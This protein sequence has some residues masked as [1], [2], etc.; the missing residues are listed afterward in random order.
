MDD[1]ELDKEDKESK[2]DKSDVVARAKSRLTRMVRELSKTHEIGRECME[3]V[4]GDQWEPDEIKSRTSTGRQMITI[5]RLSPFVNQVV[6]KNAME[7]ARIRAVPFEDAD[8]DKGK[9]VNGL[10][11]HIQSSDKSN[12]GEAFSNTFFHLGSAGFGYF[13]ID[14]EYCNEKSMDQEVLIKKIDDP[15]SVYLDPDGDFCIIVDFMDKDT[16]KEEYKDVDGGDWDVSAEIDKPDVDDVMRVE[17]FERTWKKTKLY[18]IQRYPVDVVEQPDVE[19]DLDAAIENSATP[20]TGNETNIVTVTQEELDKLPEGTFEILKERETKIPTVKR[21]VF[22]GDEQL[23]VDDWP[24]R[25]IPIIGCFARQHTLK[26][27]DKFYKAIVKD[28]ID[29]Q[30]MYN[31]YKSQDA[32]LM[33]QAPKSTWMGAQGSFKGFERDYD[34][35]NQVATARLEYNPVVSNGVMAPPPQRVAP[36]M[37]SQGFYTN[38]TMA[39]DEIKACIGI[40]DPSLGE[41]GNEVAARAILARQKQGDISTFHYTM[42]FNTAMYQAGV[43]IVDLIPHIYDGPRV[44]RI[45][46]DDM[47]D[48]VIRINQNYVDPKDGK[49]KLYDLTVGEYD[50]KVDIGASSTT[51]RMDAAENLLEFSRVVPKAGEIGADMI[52]SNLDFENSEELAMRLRAALPP[53]LL[54]RAE[55][56]QNG[57]SAEQLQLQQMQQQLQQAGQMLQG[58]AEENKKMKQ[59]LGQ[60]NI[61]EAQIEAQSDITREKIKSGAEIQKEYIRQRFQ[62][63]MPPAAGPGSMRQ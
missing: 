37:P 17:Y 42:S 15:F 33:Q 2:S 5:N 1:K 16:F 48:E 43:V 63:S 14:T 4:A 59:K 23:S 28:A 39:S 32:E 47:K 7:R 38:I 56:M 62:P 3:M 8:V 45:I 55:Q 21:Y 26:N 60:M 24:G 49:P 9:V 31:F 58:M 11:R 53:D 22:S 51:R 25:Y 27:G 41:Q 50:I 20:E 54:V 44:V 61:E 12:A 10:L 35:A 19:I 6:N 46:G 40:F 13:R 36:P 57:A 34:E 29:P 52:V 30:K 18:K